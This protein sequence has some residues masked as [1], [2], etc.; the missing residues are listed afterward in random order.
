[1][2]HESFIAV[3]R[4]PCSV[5]SSI[6]HPDPN[7]KKTESGIATNEPIESLRTTSTTTYNDVKQAGSGRPEATTL[8][9]MEETVPAT[10]K[11]KDHTQRRPSTNSSEFCP[12]AETTH[13]DAPQHTI[14]MKR[15]PVTPPGTMHIATSSQTKLK[16][17]QGWKGQTTQ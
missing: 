8:Q 5:R 1:M 9:G 16:Q 15:L 12:P 2:N 13:D 4:P 3:T 11:I 10:S 7:Q 14:D 17:E 6:R